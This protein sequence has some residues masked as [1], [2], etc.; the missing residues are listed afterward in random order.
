MVHREEC[1][2]SFRSTSLDSK[3]IKHMLITK[4]YPAPFGMRKRTIDRPLQMGPISLRFLTIA[5]LSV[6][7]LF[8]VIQSSQ[9]ESSSLRANELLEEQERL[10]QE[11]RRLELESIRLRSLN[12]IRK[13]SSSLEPVQQINYLPETGTVS[14]R[15]AP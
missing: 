13:N 4:S 8:Y 9:G 12:E 10:E 15:S 1:H 3:K 6:L 2:Q 5:L 14:L 11:Q 7:A